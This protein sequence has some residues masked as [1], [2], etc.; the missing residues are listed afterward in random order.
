MTLIPFLPNNASAPP[1]QAIVVLDRNSYTLSA[2]WNLY[3]QKWY[4]SL[5]DQN[6]NLICN[7]PLIGSPPSS[8][9]A[10]FPGFF[11]TSTL[12]YRPSTGNFEQNP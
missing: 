3:R 11:K 7:Q 5:T 6:A 10:L 4:V 8:N 2:M 1:F 12:V 9:I